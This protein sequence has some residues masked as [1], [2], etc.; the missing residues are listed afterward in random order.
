MELT[1]L[2]ISEILSNYT[3]SSEGFVTLQS[4][5][6]NSLMRHERDLFVSENGHEQRNGFR[7]RRWY[8][9]G[10]EFSLRIPRSRS[11][12]FYLVFSG[13]IRSES[14]EH[15]RLFNLFYTKVL[16][17]EDRRKL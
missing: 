14:K 7:S 13:L 8:S 16:L 10:F 11:G 1:Q 3:S 9:H 12:N 15:A 5:I 17:R 2:Q 6:M 4:L